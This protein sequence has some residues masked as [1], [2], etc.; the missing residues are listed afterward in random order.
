MF[1]VYDGLRKGRERADTSPEPLLFSSTTTARAIFC[2]FP[3]TLFSYTSLYFLLNKQL[4]AAAT[5]FFREAGKPAAPVINVIQFSN[6]FSF[7]FFFLKT[8]QATLLGLGVNAFFIRTPNTMQD[9]CGALVTIAERNQGARSQP[10]SRAA[11][12]LC[13]QLPAGTER[14]FSL[15]FIH[16]GTPDD[17]PHSRCL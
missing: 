11:S 16:R 8:M 9:L 1:H 17:A 5:H 14:S 13:P 6:P 7:F 3:R 15:A 10:L 12:S 4:P 2:Y